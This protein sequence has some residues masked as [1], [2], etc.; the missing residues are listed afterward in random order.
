MKKINKSLCLFFVCV[1]ILPLFTACKNTPANN[2][3][4]TKPPLSNSEII[5]EAKLSLKNKYKYNNVYTDVNLIGYVMIDDHKVYVDWS[6]SNNA[7]INAT[8]G[9]VYRNL[10]NQTC[11]LTATLT[12]SDLTDSVSFLYT[13]PAKKYENP[14]PNF[15]PSGSE[16]QFSIAYL[17]YD[18]DYNLT[19]KIHIYNNLSSKRTLCGITNLGFSISTS[20]IIFNDSS[21]LVKNMEYTNT[22]QS[23]F[24]CSYGNYVTI[25][26]P[27]I[28]SS[29]LNYK[30]ELAKLTNPSFSLTQSFT[31]HSK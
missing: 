24:T 9:S 29:K 23:Q 12:Y 4:N 31:Y 8:T 28:S 5:K 11:E 30:S 19:I 15:S 26:F 22:S 6:S 17:A 20:T 16:I 27:V 2:N 10:T 25:T 21:Y 14:Y 7:L 1:F 3:E 13:L 18:D